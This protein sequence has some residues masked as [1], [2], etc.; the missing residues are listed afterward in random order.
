MLECCGRQAPPWLL[1][2]E[3]NDDPIL[4]DLKSEKICAILRELIERRAVTAW[5]AGATCSSFSVAV[6]PTVRTTLWPHGAPCISDNMRAKV[7]DEN[8][9]AAFTASLA[10]LSMKHKVVWWIEN[11]SSSW[12]AAA[13]FPE[14]QKNR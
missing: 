14:A 5:G 2:F 13:L 11:P 6:T 9:L 3:I 10:V 1:C 7:A 4:Q 12:L 8:N